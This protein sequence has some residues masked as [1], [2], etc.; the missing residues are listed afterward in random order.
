MRQPLLAVAYVS[1]EFFEKRFLRLKRLF[2]RAEKQAPQSPGGVNAA[3]PYGLPQALPIREERGP[4]QRLPQRLVFEAKRPG[5]ASTG[6]M[7]SAALASTV[8]QAGQ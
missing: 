4:T 5:L 7:Q 6:D 3:E 8:E 1:Y 2:G